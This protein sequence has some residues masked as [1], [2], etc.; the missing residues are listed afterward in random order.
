MGIGYWGVP[1]PPT[2]YVTPNTVRTIMHVSLA[3]GRGRLDVT[4]PAHAHVIEPE[5]LPGLPDEHAAFIDAVRSPIEVV[6][7][8]EQVPRG[9][10]VAIVI[11]D[12]TRP[13]PSERLV[14]W[15]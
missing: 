12:I 9:A 6:P 3:Y 7:L 14:P 5:Q 4:V 8:R 2:Q 13:S 11:A 15:I 1:H 10:T